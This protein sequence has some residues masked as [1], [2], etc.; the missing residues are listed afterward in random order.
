MQNIPRNR[1]RFPD[2]HGQEP[3]PKLKKGSKS[4][5]F[6]SSGKEVPSDVKEER[7]KL[8]LLVGVL[9]ALGALAFV[10]VSLFGGNTEE[11]VENPTAS[12]EAATPAPTEDET[13]EPSD[14]GG[15]TSSPEEELLKPG[16]TVEPVVNERPDASGSCGID[17]YG[18]VVMVDGGIPCDEA[19]SVVTEVV[20]TGETTNEKYDCEDVDWYGYEEESQFSYSVECQTDTEDLIRTV[21]QNTTTVPGKM[22]EVSN[23]AGPVDAAGVVRYYFKVP[24]TDFQC[25]IFPSK[26]GARGSVGCHGTF[27]DSASMEGEAAPDSVQLDPSGAGFFTSGDAAFVPLTEDGMDYA[28]ASELEDG[29]TV[30]AYGVSCGV[31]GGEL[32][33]TSGESSMK[34]SQNSHEFN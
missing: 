27:D 11:P 5:R 14:G 7:K 8:L 26:D 15:D 34:I 23:Y 10:F 21:P 18:L 31:S 3:E 29:Q 2:E 9:A 22:A 19:V 25:S 20:E 28:E 24:G 32:T 16:E 13:P 30:Y 1:N 12:S 4:S 33:C 6:S 17:K